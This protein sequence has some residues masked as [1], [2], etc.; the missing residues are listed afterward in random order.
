MAAFFAFPLLFLSL[1]E[2][3]AGN[4]AL[5]IWN[6]FV[7]DPRVGIFSYVWM[8]LVQWLFFAVFGRFAFGLLSF[9]FSVIAF[10]HVQKMDSLGEPLYPTDVFVQASAVGNLS[11]FANVF[12]R[13]ETYVVFFVAGMLAVVG[14]F[15]FRDTAPSEKKRWF[16][17]ALLTVLQFAFVSDALGTLSGIQRLT[18][19]VPEEYSWRQ[20]ESYRKNGFWG[21]FYTNL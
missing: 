13:I 3:V 15:M 1:S 10:I 12:T 20:A 16:A 4:G 17:L 2:W 21:G 11:S 9:V 6:V 8:L 18:G 5:G 14:F 7:Q 19:L